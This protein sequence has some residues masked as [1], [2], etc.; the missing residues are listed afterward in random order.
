MNPPPF[1]VNKS[2][3]KK[4]LKYKNKY[5]AL[6]IQFGGELDENKLEAFLRYINNSLLKVPDEILGNTNV[7]ASLEVY[8]KYLLNT[9]Q[10][11]YKAVML[12]NTSGN[13]KKLIRDFIV[14]LN[15]VIPY[16]CSYPSPYDNFINYLDNIICANPNIIGDNY[17]AL[18]YSF[19]TPICNDMDNYLD[20]IN[21]KTTSQKLKE[22]LH[23]ITIRKQFLLSFV[24]FNRNYNKQN[25]YEACN[26]PDTTPET[27]QLTP[28]S[29]SGPKPAQ[30]SPNARARKINGL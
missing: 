30:S 11:N 17:C 25:S 20:N 23:I 3:Q 10:L 27:K 13:I 12:L 5:N 15:K 6:K 9:K 8:Q 19:N 14:E 28:T 21:K 2:Y 16:T 4:Y 22:I 18:N 7:Y 1:S 26:N 29:P 24:E